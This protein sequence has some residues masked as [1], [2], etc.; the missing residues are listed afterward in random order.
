MAGAATRDLDAMAGATLAETYVLRRCLGQGGMGVVYEAEHTRLPQRF[1]VKLMRS[2]PRTRD[3]ALLR[4]R[5]EAEIA[6]TLR[7]PHIASVVDFNQTDDGT[8]YL[9]MEL[10]EGESLTTRLARGPL[11]RDELL[12]LCRQVAAAL[13]A[14]HER[15]VVHRDLKPDNVF[16]C[17]ARGAPFAV[18]L[19]D[20]GISRVESGEAAVTSTGAFLGTPAYMSPEQARGERSVDA[21]VDVHAFAV[22]LYEVV[23]GRRPFSGENVFELIGQ[24]TREM[25][26]AIDGAPAALDQAIRRGLAKDREQRTATAQELAAEVEAALAEHPT[27]QPGAAVTAEPAAARRRSRLPLVL[28]GLLLAGAA[29]TVWIQ[30]NGSGAQPSRARAPA[31]PPPAVPAV[32]VDA[33]PAAPA[34]AAPLSTAPDEV[35]IQ[36]RVAPADAEVLLDGRTPVTGGSIRL[37]RSGERRRLLVRAAGHA[38]RTVDFVPDREQTVTVRLERR[39]RGRAP[40][41]SG[42]PFI[43]GSEL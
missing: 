30:L 29:V 16:L 24:I 41:K 1:A 22:L 27:W 26:P 17:A 18:K 23:A 11:A 19:L 10:L 6:C 42:S 35:A 8:P 39:R 9:V 32:V 38:P 13:T 28:A 34:P 3:E 40:A 7:S 4:F 31:L 43:G 12:L 25:P 15:R 14:A 2:D 33:A 20:F 37:E 21:R 36:L 5:R